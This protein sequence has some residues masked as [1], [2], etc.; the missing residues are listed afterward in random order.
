MWTDWRPDVIAKDFD[1]CR[2][3]GIKTLRVFPLWPVFQPIHL[4]RRWNATPLEYRFGEHPIPNDELGRFGISAEAMAKFATLMELAS[5][6]QLNI[7]PSLITGWMS[8]RLFVPPALEGRNLVTDPVALMWSIRFV[9][10]FVRYFRDSPTILAWNLGNECN[11]LSAAGSREAAWNWTAS[12]ANAIRSEDTSRTIISGMHGLNSAREGIWTIEDQA[13]LAD[14]LTVH[15]YPPF[16]AH[17]GRDAINTLRNGLHATAEA[18]FYAD[19]GGRNCLAEEVGTL[20]PMFASEKI[21]AD[22][23]RV[24]LFSLVAHGHIGMLWWCAFDQEH[25]EHAPY[26]WHA[27]ERE[28][29][30]FR[31]DSSSKPVAK[32]ISSFSHLLA[33]FPSLPPHRRDAVCIV[34]DDQDS[35]G[36]AYGSLILAKQAGFDLTFQTGHQELRDSSLYLLPSL[37]SEPSRRFLTKLMRRVEAGAT[38]YVSLNDALLSSFK[39]F[40]GME[41]QTRVQRTHPATI[42]FQGSEFSSTSSH[43]LNLL[44][45]GATV[46]AREPDG[47]AAFFRHPHGKGNIFFLTIP[48]EHHVSITPGVF[49]S[50][51]PNFHTFYEE[52]ASAALSKRIVRRSHPHLGVTEHPIDETGIFAFLINYSPEDLSTDL[53]INPEW[54]V[55]KAVH[56]SVTNGSSVYI[57]ANDAI[58]L[59]LQKIGNTPSP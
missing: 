22:Y 33:Q 28:L 1:L 25:L 45:A 41:V 40:F 11:N 13:E 21:A 42:S 47:N 14:T 16:T 48:I 4:L 17:C 46:L 26:D 43:R 29:G 54:M 51:A 10:G 7:I 6:H 32:V 12:I 15:P 31:S 44:E 50:G 35:W 52:F 57:K 9:T 2:K 5:L 8:G 23:L 34:T 49:D 24:T 56:G 30:L 39:H 18:S 3:T 19:I 55:V 36:V 58:V 27:F 20:G 38:L 59:H 53:S 37:S